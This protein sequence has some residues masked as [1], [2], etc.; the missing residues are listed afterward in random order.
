M[1]L[2]VDENIKASITDLLA[3]E[4][5]DV[6]RIQ[7]VELGISDTAVIDYC[8]AEGRVLL[9]NDDDFFDFDSHP[10]ALFLTHQTTPARDVVNAIRHI[11]RQL[12]ADELEG[13]VLH[14]P[15]GWV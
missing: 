10:G 13:I 5:H 4:G 14:V 11:E 2:A 15:D 3:Q 6:V 9:T 1:N 8:R 7:D 12:S